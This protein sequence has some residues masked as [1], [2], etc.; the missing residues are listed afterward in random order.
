MVRLMGVRLSSK[1]ECV[2]V[3]VSGWV[4]RICVGM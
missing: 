2:C 1:R 4:G 3:F